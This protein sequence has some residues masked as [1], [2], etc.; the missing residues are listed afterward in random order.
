[1]AGPADTA[2]ACR[3]TQP[4]FYQ[5]QKCLNSV[6][7]YKNGYFYKKCKKCL[8][9]AYPFKPV[10]FPLLHGLGK[11]VSFRRGALPQKADRMPSG[12]Q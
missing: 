2:V 11:L 12:R 3:A 4:A 7:S 1:M 10:Y 8:S 5:E 6:K 9:T